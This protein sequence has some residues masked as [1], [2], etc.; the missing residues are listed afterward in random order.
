MYGQ[1]KTFILSCLL[2]GF[3]FSSSAQ[4][5]RKLTA[6]TQKGIPIEFFSLVEEP[7]EEEVDFPCGV[8]AIHMATS[9]NLN[10]APFIKREKEF[11]EPV[12]PAWMATL[13]YDD[14]NPQAK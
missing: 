8:S 7:I 6:Y 10:I 9:P 14:D 12:D 2:L 4:T 13:N 5:L 3:T 11:D 1:I